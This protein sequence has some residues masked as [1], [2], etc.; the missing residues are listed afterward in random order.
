MKRGPSRL[1]NTKGMR[2][3]VG[4]SPV[5]VGAFSYGVEHLNI[6]EWG[7]GIKLTIGRYCSFANNVSFFLGGRHAT[8]FCT[9]YPF[10]ILH[11]D[12]FPYE[13]QHTP[14]KSKDITVGHDVWIA[15]DVTVMPGVTIGNG[16]VIAAGSH[17][18]SD[19]P[20]YTVFGGNP[21]E[22][23]KPR[24]EPTIIQ[25]LTQLAWWEFDPVHVREMV[26]TLMAEPTT[27]SLD[28]LLKRFRK[29]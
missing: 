5:Q 3:M 13:M 28:A 16:A 17:V 26:P 20:D 8:E 23:I 19:V 1:H 14:R 4:K 11:Q 7:Q 18:V 12:I 15:A 24:F 10:G 29:G 22:Y 27:D 9:T 6:R 21:A 2:F 25:R